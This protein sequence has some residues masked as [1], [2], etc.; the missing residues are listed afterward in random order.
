M[1]GYENRGDIDLKAY[2]EV[3]VSSL[4]GFYYYVYSNYM[5]PLS[6]TQYYNLWLKR[7]NN[8]YEVKLAE[9]VP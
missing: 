4:N 3:Y 1:N 2:V 9:Y 8:I 5:T 6:D 7:I